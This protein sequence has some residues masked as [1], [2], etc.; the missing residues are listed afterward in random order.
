MNESHLVKTPDSVQ[1]IESPFGTQQHPVDLA[2]LGE[3]VA[4]TEESQSSDDSL[5]KAINIA[6]GILGAQYASYYHYDNVSQALIFRKGLGYSVEQLEM[7]RKLVIRS[8]DVNNA[9][10]WVGKHCRPL[11]L[12][13]GTPALRFH[14][15]DPFIYASLWAPAVQAGKLIGV[16]ELASQKKDAF[17]PGDEL[18]LQSITNCIVPLLI[19][20]S[21]SR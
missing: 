19:D 13:P 14:R 2:S 17:L 1:V 9:V 5:T 18:F 8:E 11:L 12:S 15:I 10:R 4:L 21:L 3:P 20:A 6:A 7:L 16:L